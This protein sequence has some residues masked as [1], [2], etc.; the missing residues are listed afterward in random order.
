MLL[1][2]FDFEL[3]SELIAQT[4]A[5]PRHASKMLVVNNDGALL[6]KQASDLADYIEEG[7]LV[8]FNNSKVIPAKFKTT[9]L[10][11]NLHQDLGQGVWKAF[12]KK[13]RKV[14]LGDKID[15]ADDCYV[16]V[17]DKNGG[18]LTLRF[19]YEQGNDLDAIHRYGMMP[20]PPYIKQ[21]EDAAA[22]YQTIFAA[23]DGSVAAPTAG[24]H[25]TPE[26]FAKLKNKNIEHCFVTLHVGAGT[27]LPIKTDSIKEHV[28]HYETG[29]I[30]QDTKNLINNAKK[31]GRKIIAVGTTSL[32]FLESASNEDGVIEHERVNTNLFIT[33]G[34]KFKMV[35]KLLTNFHLPCTTLFVLVSTFAGLSTMKA[36][37]EHA[38]AKKYRFY[39]YGD[40]C[41]LT[42]NDEV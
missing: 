7:S 31:Q 6:D 39:S 3:P 42:R 9:K 21:S 35:D 22:H 29:F 40:C 23:E 34:Y 1:S 38:I 17:L 5:N 20:L 37:Y 19:C 41:L 11:F 15:I 33:P 16:M 24:L 25:F 27:F 4:P 13:T 28:M 30:T 8:I 32:R 14:N 18:E 36:A 10:E 2:N 26:L 12:A